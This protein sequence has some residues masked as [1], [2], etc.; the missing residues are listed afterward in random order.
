MI[1]ACC[2]WCAYQKGWFYQ[3]NTTRLIRIKKPK[4]IASLLWFLLILGHRVLSARADNDFNLP[5]NTVAIYQEISVHISSMSMPSNWQCWLLSY[6]M[7]IQV[8]VL[9]GSGVGLDFHY[10]IGWYEGHLSVKS[11]LSFCIQSWKPT[12]FLSKREITKDVKRT[13]IHS[14]FRFLVTSLPCC[15]T[16]LIHLL[17]IFQYWKIF[18]EISP[19]QSLDVCCLSMFIW[20]CV[21]FISCNIL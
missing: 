7:P 14:D 12:F 3:H 9:R 15:L 11:A 16:F 5:R 10:E 21:P 1:L 4:V 17:G 18:Q 2:Y 13:H 19:E 8:F 20:V 6:S